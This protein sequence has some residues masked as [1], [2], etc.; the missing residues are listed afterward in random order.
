MACDSREE[1]TC[2]SVV[3]NQR[4]RC[5]Q[6]FQDSVRTPSE[7]QDGAVASLQMN[8]CGSQNQS[9]HQGNYDYIR[10]FPQ[11]EIRYSCL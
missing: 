7:Q 9:D 4:I 2:M 8:F 1:N 6:V 3:N 11:P 10:V 5:V